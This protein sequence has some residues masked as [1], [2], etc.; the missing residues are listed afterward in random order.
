ME[1][2]E[3]AELLGKELKLL[4]EVSEDCKDNSSFYKYLPGLALAMV[5]IAEKL[6]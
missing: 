3:I 1:K 6:V 5:R 2:T 4:Q